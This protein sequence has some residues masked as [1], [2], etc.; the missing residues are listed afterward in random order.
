ML[1]V[2]CSGTSPA[3]PTTTSMVDTTTSA[4]P[5]TSTTTTIVPATV[6]PV[7][8]RPATTT[9]STS[10]DIPAGAP[11]IVVATTAEMEAVIG[12]G[13]W[14]YALPVPQAGLAQSSWTADDDHGGTLVL[15]MPATAADTA[16]FFRLQLSQH[17]FQFTEERAGT[18]SSIHLGEQGSIT[19]APTSTTT[20]SVTITVK[21]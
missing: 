14:D 11:A 12:K 5:T 19:V 18:I 6:L 2:G 3:L 15:A 17:G 8:T 10:L 7:P 13:T 21:L 9:T 16:G 1:A 20:C 4:V